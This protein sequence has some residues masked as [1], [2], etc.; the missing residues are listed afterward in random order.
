MPVY[1]A[2]HL[3]N[4]VGWTKTTNLDDRTFPW[5]P[6]TNGIEVWIGPICPYSGMTKVSIPANAIVQTFKLINIFGQDSSSKIGIYSHNFTVVLT[7]KVDVLEGDCISTIPSSYQINNYYQW[8]YNYTVVLP[9]KIQYGVAFSA[10]P[11]EKVDWFHRGTG[12]RCFDIQACRDY[13]PGDDV[14]KYIVELTPETIALQGDGIIYVDE[15][16]LIKRI[17]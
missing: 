13:N 8:N 15:I 11:Y 10:E 3:P 2:H 12:I 7:H 9:Q 14:S 5:N 4:R 1:R 6:S 16:K 17:D